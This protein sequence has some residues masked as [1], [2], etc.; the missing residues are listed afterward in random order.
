M[1]PPDPLC[2]SVEQRRIGFPLYPVE[3]HAVRCRESRWGGMPNGRPTLGRF[4]TATGESR[5]TRIALHGVWSDQWIRANS[6]RSP[7][8][9]R[10]S[11]TRRPTAPSIE[12]A[13]ACDAAS[14]ASSAADV[15]RLLLRNEERGARGAWGEGYEK[16]CAHEATAMP[17]LT[18]RGERNAR[19]QLP[20]HRNAAN[21]AVPL[22]LTENTSTDT[23]ISARG[24][25][26]SAAC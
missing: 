7:A 6:G 12:S 15:A 24:R 1:W 25:R 2:G 9:S 18:F 23:R 14:V 3:R 20:H 13:G 21:G 11:P 22:D 26:S 16:S 5:S 17:N 10:R 19:R 8:V 4:T